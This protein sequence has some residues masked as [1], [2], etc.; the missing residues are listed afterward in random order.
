MDEDGQRVGGD[1]FGRDGDVGGTGFV[2][3]GTEGVVRDAAAGV[4]VPCAGA[5]MAVRG[6]HIG[7]G[8][9]GGSVDVCADGNAAAFAVGGSGQLHLTDL[10]VVER[11][12]G[13]ERLEG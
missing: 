3:G 7:D 11:D 2:S 6:V 4:A 5:E 13:D 9:I 10:A 12:S 1:A 8:H